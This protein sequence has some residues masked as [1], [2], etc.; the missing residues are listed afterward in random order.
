[1]SAGMVSIRHEVRANGPPSGRGRI[2]PFVQLTAAAYRPRWSTPA[3]SATGDGA[4]PSTQRR[5]G[6]GFQHAAIDAVARLDRQ[7]LDHRRM[8]GDLADLAITL[9]ALATFATNGILAVSAFLIIGLV[10]VPM[11]PAMVMRVVHPGPLVN[12]VH[13]SA[14][15]AGLAFGA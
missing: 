6:D 12:T 3:A 1:M 15:T 13:T 9:T 2:M 8:T 14:I 11:N 4:G 7:T 10:G 5:R